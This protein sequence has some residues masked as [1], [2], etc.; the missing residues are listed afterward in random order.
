MGTTKEESRRKTV[1]LHVRF[2]P[3]DMETA[4]RNCRIAGYG[5]MSRFARARLTSTG[6]ARRAP[7]RDFAESSSPDAPVPEWLRDELGR[8]SEQVRGV[9]ADYNRAVAVMGALVKSVSARETQRLIIRRAARLDTLTRGLV[10]TLQEMKEIVERAA[11]DAQKK[12]E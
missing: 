8:L 6:P 5:S 1:Y 11:G 3:A 12:E 9:A 10:D 4:R 7:A 2:T